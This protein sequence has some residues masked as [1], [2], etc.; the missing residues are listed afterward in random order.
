MSLGLASMGFS[1]PAAMGAAYASKKPVLAFCGDGGIQMNI[2]ELQALARDSIP[3]KVIII[4]NYALGM[5]REFQERNFQKK[6][7]QSVP[8][9]GYTIPD[10]E[11][12]ARAYNIDYVS[13]KTLDQIDAIDFNDGKPGII[14]IMLHEDTYLT[15]RLVRGMPISYMTPEMDSEH[16][17]EYLDM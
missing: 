16:Y 8:Q 3:V 2:Q 9:N 7:I 5:I 11:K 10:F 4:N 15:P 12:I 14:E 13:V 1:L 17:K 6:Y